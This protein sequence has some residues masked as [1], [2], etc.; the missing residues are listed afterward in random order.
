MFEATYILVHRW[1]SVIRLYRIIVYRFL[2]VLSQLFHI[3]KL[4]VGYAVIH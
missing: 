4:I 3:E 2:W 1:V